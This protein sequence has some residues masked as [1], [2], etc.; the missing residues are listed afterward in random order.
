MPCTR[1]TRRPLSSALVALTRFASLAL[2]LA[3]FVVVFLPGREAR[4][5]SLSS[6]G[7]IFLDAA[8]TSCTL[9]TSGGCTADCTPLKFQLACSASLELS[10]TGGC[11]ADVD[12]DCSGSCEA[13]CMGGCTADPGSFDCNADCTGSCEG[14]CT[15]ECASDSN[16]SECMTS[17]QASCNTRC[18]ASCMATAPS[19]SCD[20]KCAASCQGSC[21]ASAN[22]DCDVKCQ[23]SGYAG[24]EANL[25]G[26]CNLQCSAPMGALFCNGSYVNVGNDLGAAAGTTAACSPAR[27][28]S[29]WSSSV[30][31]GRRAPEHV[32]EASQPLDYGSGR[33]PPSGRFITDRSSVLSTACASV[34]ALMMSR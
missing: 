33:R 1:Q 15:S 34:Q 30:A 24:C 17:C 14:G 16:M 5:D 19:A 25:T 8:N 12:V 4:A 23:E 31:V 2:A 7:D 32:H 3:A 10:C 29:A 18:S 11:N 26:G 6:C 28:W 20:A 21:T 9:E 27:W 22:L 13:T